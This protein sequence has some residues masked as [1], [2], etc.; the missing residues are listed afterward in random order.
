[1]KYSEEVVEFGEK[2]MKIFSVTIGLSENHLDQASGGDIGA[3]LK[4]N[5][6]PKCPQPNLTLGLSRHLDP[7]GMTLLLPDENLQ[8]LQGRHDNN[9][10]TDKLVPN[11]FVINIGD[12]KINNC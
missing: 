6:C 2:L 4:A 9:W 11:A 7:G 3:C 10:I 12:Q 5:D 1:M 8:W